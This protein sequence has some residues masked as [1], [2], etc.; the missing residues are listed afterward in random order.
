[1]LSQLSTQIF[2]LLPV[3]TMPHMH[4]VDGLPSV[5]LPTPAGDE[6]HA[7]LGFA[8]QVVSDVVSKPSIITFECVSF[9]QFWTELALPPPTPMLMSVTAWG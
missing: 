9:L 1:M 3:T 5:L 8:C 2:Y 4:E 7:V 6:V